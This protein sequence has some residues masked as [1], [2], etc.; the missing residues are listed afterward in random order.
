MFD[1]EL[2]NHKLYFDLEWWTTK[3]N[4]IF[5]Y[6]KRLFSWGDDGGSSATHEFEWNFGS[7]ASFTISSGMQME[8]W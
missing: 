1:M 3:L 8:I 4:S 2:D 5:R 7:M 6:G